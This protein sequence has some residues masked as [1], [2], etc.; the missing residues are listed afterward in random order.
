MTNRQCSSC[1]ACCEGWLTA[2]INGI[3]IKPGTPCVN[4]TKQGC[5]IYETR[6]KNPCVSFKCGWLIEPDKFPEHMKPS[7]CG[8]IIV[9]SQWGDKGVVKAT[10]V[11]EKIPSDTLEW[12]MAF[13][14]E[15]SLPLMF[16][17]HLFEDGKYIGLTKKLYGPQS[18]IREEDTR[19]TP[20]D[21]MRF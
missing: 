11:G 5:K 10:P 16:N 6:P 20:E 1:T 14:R 8:A 13:A 19:I 7:K 18:F 4:C 17:E 12:L 15:H 2:K 21:I 9:F 3:Q